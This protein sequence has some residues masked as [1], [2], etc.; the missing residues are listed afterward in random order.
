MYRIPR[1]QFTELK[2]VSKMKVPN[3]DA[4]IPLSRET[5]LIMTYR[6]KEE[7][8]WKRGQLGEKENMIRYLGCRTEALRA[9][10]KNG[11]RQ[12]GEV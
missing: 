10:R 5:K 12:P 7:P 6:G 8:E 2:K 3:E 9:S 11:N 4:S 1:I